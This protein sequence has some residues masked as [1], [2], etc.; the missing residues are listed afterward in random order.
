MSGQPRPG[1][2]Q[3]RLATAWPPARRQ[4]VVAKAPYTGGG[5]LRPA[6]RGGRHLR[7][8]PTVGRRPQGAAASGQLARGC[9]PV[10]RLQGSAAC[11]EATRAAPTRD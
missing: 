2:L 11:D 1:L 5:R 3:G 8:W 9:S 10:A 6:R 7:A 4:P